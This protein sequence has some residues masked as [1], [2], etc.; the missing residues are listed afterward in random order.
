MVGQNPQ[1][2]AIQAAAMAHIM[3]HV[4]FQY[5]KDIETQLGAMLPPMDEDKPMTPEVELQVSKLA[6]YAAA[7]LLQKDQ[8]EAQQQA[9][10]QQAQDPLLALQQQDLQIKQ[11]EVERKKVKDQLDAAAKA[12]EIQLKEAELQAK[13]QIENL[14]LMTEAAGRAD[15]LAA[16][17]GDDEARYGMDLLKMGHAAS[18]PQPEKA[19]PP[20]GNK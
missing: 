1:A 7:R 11:A 17:D 9:A 2:Q 8:A 10:Q 4:A 20:K 5:R 16:R 18:Q 13:Y 15:E 3:E 19:A 6:S 14:K 12:D